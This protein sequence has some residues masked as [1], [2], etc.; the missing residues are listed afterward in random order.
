MSTIFGHFL[1][2]A[3]E[4]GINFLP[5]SENPRT[6]KNK[7]HGLETSVASEIPKTS[8]SIVK[9]QTARTVISSNPLRTTGFNIKRPIEE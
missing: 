2:S 7:N 6:E 5:V 3:A 4:M 9:K 8:H 1:E